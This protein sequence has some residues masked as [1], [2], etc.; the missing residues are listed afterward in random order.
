MGPSRRPPSYAELLDMLSEC[1]QRA[2]SDA[3]V[4]ATLDEAATLSTRKNTQAG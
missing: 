2:H 4:P 1:E 3:M